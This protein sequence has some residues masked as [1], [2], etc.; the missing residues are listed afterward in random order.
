MASNKYYGMLGFHRGSHHGSSVIR[1]STGEDFF[2]LSISETS[3]ISEPKDTE[4]LSGSSF[5]ALF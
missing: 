2:G 3:K 5:V 4:F 1:E